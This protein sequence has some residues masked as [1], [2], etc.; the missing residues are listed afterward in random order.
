[1]VW[2]ETNQLLTPTQKVRRGALDE[3]YAAR[4]EDWHSQDRKVLWL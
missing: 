2:S 4:Y 1:M 3:L